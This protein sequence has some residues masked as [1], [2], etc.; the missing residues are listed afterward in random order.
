MLLPLLASVALLAGTG[1]SHNLGEQGLSL[2]LA[3]EAKRSSLSAEVTWDSSDKVETGDGWLLDA[4]TD[5]H[6]GLLTLGAGYSHRE[7]SQWTKDVWWARAGVQQGPLW[8]LAS[9]A[10]TSPNMEAKLEARLTM[11]HRWAVVKPRAWVAWH[12]TA[13][14][15]G[16]YA[17]GLSML[18][19]GGTSP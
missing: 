9:V 14:E 8:L 17:W 15:L 3:A 4:A 1:A 7:T 12:T 5:W 19:G 16:G 18:I 6:T 13:E 10:P 11:R 2:V